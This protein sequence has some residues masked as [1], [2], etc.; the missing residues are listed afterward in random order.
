MWLGN[1]FKWFYVNF[2]TGILRASSFPEGIKREPEKKAA[3]TQ[4][5]GY[6]SR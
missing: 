1:I 6:Q 2:L 5:L 3:K 4:L